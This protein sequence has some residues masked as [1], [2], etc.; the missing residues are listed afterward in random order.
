MWTNE[1]KTFLIKLVEDGSIKGFAEYHTSTAIKFVISANQAWID[2]IAD[3]YKKLKLETKISTMNMHAFDPSGKIKWYNTAEDVVEEHFFVRKDAYQRRKIMICEK[4]AVDVATSQNKSR[5][6]A[7]ILDGSINL[8][9]G[10]M[11]EGDVV[12]QLKAEKFATWSEIQ[13]AGKGLSA[14]AS[15]NGANEA[16]L[17]LP[18][19]SPKQVDV[20]D[21]SYLLSMPIHSLTTA[22]YNALVQDTSKS[23]E[24]YEKM[25]KIAPEEL[26]LQDIRKFLK[27]LGDDY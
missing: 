14:S 25:L 3:I 7:G 9:T 4:L 13:C 17:N 10:K 22:R 24:E 1:Y 19:A 2:G 21:Y 11:A 26:W 23:L 16:M 8:L 15:V 27:L 6:I 20:D 12:S 5:F 18:K